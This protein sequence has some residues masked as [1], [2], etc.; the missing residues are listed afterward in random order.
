[1]LQDVTLADGSQAPL[2]GPVAK[3]S[4]TPTRIR[5]AAPA[6]GRDNAQVL[7][8]VGVDAARQRELRE[9]GVL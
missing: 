2:L 9:R 3:F 4:R 8:E 6:V 7:D 1:M 5:S